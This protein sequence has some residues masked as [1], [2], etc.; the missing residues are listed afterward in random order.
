MSQAILD[1]AKPPTPT[2]GNRWSWA[3]YLG[4][5][6]TWCIGMFLPVLL[7]RDYGPWAW[8]IFAVPNAVGAAAMGWVM[9]SREMSHDYTIRHASACRL[10]SFVT[11]AF[12]LF[13]SIWWL[14]RLLG[15]VGYLGP[16]I[17]VQA[18][19]TPITRS[20]WLRLGGAIAL[21]VS[22]AM[23]AGLKLEHSL[24]WPSSRGMMTPA[25]S[26][27]LA[28]VCLAGF[29][30]CPYLDLTFHRARQ[31]TNNTDSRFAFGV[32]F[33][34]LFASMIVLTFFY[35]HDVARLNSGVNATTLLSMTGQYLLATHW[36]V[37]MLYTV[38]VHAAELFGQGEQRDDRGV[39]RSGLGLWLAIGLAA[40][41]IA[42]VQW[43]ENLGL[44]F[45]LAECA[46][47]VFMSF[48]GLLF[49]AYVLLAL[50][51]R[52]VSV[53]VWLIVSAGASPFYG[54][55]FLYGQ[56]GWAIAGV[57]VVAAGSCVGRYLTPTAMPSPIG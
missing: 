19:F 35:A 28:L 38:N 40:G 31:S 46:Y 9:R 51:G 39:M 2:D 4:A 36:F 24:T 15:T 10:F 6:W 34:V 22:I 44:R 23:A 18:A 32:G 27:G 5:S 49:P 25:E 47:R 50:G 52:R 53:P 21:L 8:A 48:Y 16:I 17:L 37:Q 26:V 56:M 43:N 12:Q 14:P 33:C 1:Y 30:T 57:S 11:I 41:L 45:G 20:N 29:L 42:T 54:L 55:A 3:A 13:F 7:I